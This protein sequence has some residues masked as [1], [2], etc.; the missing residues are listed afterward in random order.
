V[1]VGAWPSS[2]FGGLHQASAPVAGPTPL[3]DVSTTKRF[4]PI[5]GAMRRP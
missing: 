4:H 2:R 3:R 1:D 5:V